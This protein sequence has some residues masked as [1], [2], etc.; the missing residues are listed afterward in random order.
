MLSADSFAEQFLT[1]SLDEFLML[2]QLG[3][4][5]GLGTQYQLMR[6]C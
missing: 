3:H 2:F 6:M 5:Y 1:F 4:V